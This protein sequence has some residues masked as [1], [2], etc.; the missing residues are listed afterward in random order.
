M[1]DTKY[2]RIGSACWYKPGKWRD[3]KKDS[4][5]WKAGKLRAWSTDYEEFESGPG[6]YPVA[7]VEDDETGRCSSID[8]TRV[9][10]ADSQPS[11]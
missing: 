6:L 8:V 1:N 5:D 11:T 10:F 9:S 2:N 3:D 4:S 7:V